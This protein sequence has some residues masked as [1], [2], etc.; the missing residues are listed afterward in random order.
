MT[1]RS[2]RET[3][4]ARKQWWL[5]ATGV[6]LFGAC[7]SYILDDLDVSEL[8]SSEPQGVRLDLLPD[9]AQPK[10]I[11]PLALLAAMAALGMAGRNSL[12]AQQSAS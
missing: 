1:D 9:S 3:Y 8:Y 2:P 11:T 7:Y 5:F 10:I 6:L 12:R 4:L